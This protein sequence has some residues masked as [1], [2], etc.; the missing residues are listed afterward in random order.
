ME[1][2]R[3]FFKP[4]LSFAMLVAGIVMSRADVGWFAGGT[5]RLVWYVAAFLP[6]G[7]GVM[8]EAWECVMKKDVF[9]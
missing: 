5:V 9:S 2:E 6:V 4:A 3:S 1:E 8:K 7:I